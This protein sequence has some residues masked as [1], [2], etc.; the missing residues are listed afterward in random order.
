[1]SKIPDGWV[2]QP[3]GSF[4]KMKAG[5][6]GNLPSGGCEIESELHA[7]IKAYCRHK[8]WIC[9]TGSMAHRAMRTIGECDFTILADGGRVFFI[10]AKTRVGKLSPEQQGVVIWA[11]KLGHKIHIV[12][13]M[14]QFCAIVEK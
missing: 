1:M 12:R 5:A 10:E 3:D 13:S 6:T 8:A 7:E 2:R 4:S 11:E 14:Q 9:F